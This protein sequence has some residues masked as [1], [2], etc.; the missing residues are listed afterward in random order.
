MNSQKRVAQFEQKARAVSA[1]VKT[2]AG[3]DHALAYALNICTQ[4]EGL[5]GSGV[6]LR[7]C[8]FRSGRRIVRSET[9]GKADGR[10]QPV[11]AGH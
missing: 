1:V 3:I 11:S 8:P 6:G 7:I 10:T 2:M 4:K 9:M 5:R